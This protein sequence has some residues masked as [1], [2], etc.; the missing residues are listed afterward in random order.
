MSNLKEFAKLLDGRDVA[1][2]SF[3]LLS[4]E[5]SSKAKREGIV[6]VTGYSDDL[7]EFDGAMKDEFDCFDGGTVYVVKD[8]IYKNLQDIPKG[9]IIHPV[10]AKWYEKMDW[11]QLG[12]IPWS[13]DTDIPHETF[14]LYN[15]G[16]LWCEGIVFQMDNLKD[17]TA[18]PAVDEI[19]F[20]KVKP[21]A[22]IPTKEPENAGYD[23]YPCFELP[24]MAIL[25]HTTSLVPTGIACALNEKWYFQVEERGS[26]GSKGIKKSAGVIDSGYRGEIFIAVTNT[27]D[28][29][30][31]ISK[32]PDDKSYMDMIPDWLKE[33]GVIIY[34]YKKAIAQ[35]VLHEVPR[36]KTIEISYESLL[37]IPSKRMTGKL[38][39]SGA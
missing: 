10:T 11:E 27:N 4:E 16:E 29:S 18:S 2:D 23:I 15:G 21:D 8:N 7:M 35:L 12:M 39:S 9:S 32:D 3:N 26:T 14:I 20:A 6:V 37:K 22:I 38:G 5:E 33:N 1:D 36:M 25:P 17:D 34:P 31:I 13:Y 28:K 24:N 30:L 19:L